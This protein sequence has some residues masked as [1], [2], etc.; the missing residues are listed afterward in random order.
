MKKR[1]MKKPG[2][3]WRGGDGDFRMGGL[4]FQKPSHKYR[5]RDIPPGKKPEISNISF[6]QILNQ[7]QAGVSEPLG[8]DQ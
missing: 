5:I 8:L 7:H 3:W 1:E 4:L 6:T 2:E